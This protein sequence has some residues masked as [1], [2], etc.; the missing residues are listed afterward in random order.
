MAEVPAEGEEPWRRVSDP[1]TEA[2]P[3]VK[4]PGAEILPLESRVA[5]AEGV[6]KL[7]EPPPATRAL[8]VSVPPPPDVTQV[9]VRQMV[10]PES[11]SEKVRAAVRLDGSMVAAKPVKLVMAILPEP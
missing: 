8:A 6:C 4:S 9:T 1:A 10:P 2:P 11:G 3:E 5:V 7:C